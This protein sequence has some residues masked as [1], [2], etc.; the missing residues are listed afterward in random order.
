MRASSS[1]CFFQ[2]A[3]TPSIHRICL[4]S[5]VLFAIVVA[6][7]ARA[8]DLKV[9]KV[10]L[11]S[12]TVTS[13]PPGINCGGDCNEMYPSTA[14]VTLTATPDA[15]SV[16]VR[17]EGDGAGTANPTVVTMGS[18]RSVRAIFRL[19]TPF[20]PITDFSP[21]GLRTYLSANPDV[22]TA[23]RFMSA[24]PNDF[25]QNWILMTRSESLQTGTALFPRILLPSA[26][27]R[28]VFTLGLAEHSSYP[29]AHPDAIEYMQWDAAQK[30]FRFHEVILRNVPAMGD[31]ISPT[32]RRF[33][34]RPRGVSIDDAKCS[35]CHS[36]RNVVNLN[37]TVIPP[38]PG[39]FPATDGV[40]PGTVKAK[41]KPNW[42]AYDS[43][44]GMMPFNRDRIYQGS[45]EAAAFRRLLNL[46]TWSNNPP[47][48]SI[49]EQL[50]LQPPD[51]FLPGGALDMA[52]SIPRDHVI[53][54]TEGGPQ[55]GHINFVFDTAPPISTEPA[56]SGPASLQT[57]YAFEGVA[58]PP[59]T[60]TT[61]SIVWGGTFITLHHSNIPTSDEGRG[62]R[63][64]DALGG[65]ASIDADGDGVL[66]GNLNA[67][68]ITDELISHRFA[69]GSRPIDIRPIALAITKEM[70]RV[71]AAG[72]TVV[73]TPALTIDLGFFEA[74]HG[75]LRI[76]D[77]VAD[78]RA[79]A[80]LLP[81]R[82][83]DIQKRN[84]DRTDDVYLSPADQAAPDGANGLIQQYGAD[85]SAGAVATLDK[86]RQEVFRR[87]VDLGRGDVTV[88]NR[89]YVDREEYGTND[90]PT[91]P[92][93]TDPNTE[94][95]ALFR[96]FLEPL[97]VSVDKWSMGV[98]GR[99]RTYTF[100]DVFRAYTNH[101]KIA[102]RSSLLNPADMVP[103]L[104]NPDNDTQLI[105][106]VNSTLGFLPLAT[107]VPRYTDVQR[108]FNKSC[109]EC[110]GGLGYPP[111]HNYGTFVDLSENEDPPSGLP[112]MPS[113]RLLRSYDTA[114]AL[115]VGGLTFG[116][117][118]R[119]TR[120]GTLEN[121]R[122]GL[123]D[124]MPCG[125]PRL[126]QADIDTIRRWIQG[127]PARPSTTGDP[128]ITTVDGVNYDFQAAGEFVLLR[129]EYLEIQARQTAVQTAGPLG[130][131]PHTGLTSCVSVN[132][133][134]AVR[135]GSHRITYQPNLGGQSEGRGLQLRVDGK[136]VELGS[137]GIP[138]ASG[139]R[140]VRTAAP[141][142]IQLEAAGGL[143][144]VVTPGWWPQHQL[145]FLNIDTRN[146]RAITGLMGTI[147]PGNWLPALPEGT[148][149]GP[150]P[151]DL[152][153]RFQDLYVKFGNAWRVTDATSL[154]DYAP[155][156]STRTFQLTSFPNEDP[157]VP[158]TVPPL[159]GSINGPPAA[160][161][162]F[163]EAEACC[164]GILNS[165]RKANCIK[166]VMVTGEC[167]FG[168]TYILA[169]QI[170]RNRYPTFPTLV[171]PPD[172]ATNLVGPIS[173]TWNH[174]N[175]ADGDPITYRHYVWPV[176]DRPNNNNA[177]PVVLQAGLS[178][179]GDA[180]ARL[181]AW[182]ACLL[183][184]ALVLLGLKK[185]PGLPIVLVLAILAVVALVY[186]RGRRANVPVTNAQ[187]VT[188]TVVDLQPHQAYFWKVIAEDGQ[189]GTV[190]SET[191][192]LEMK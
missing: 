4:A 81:R 125:G 6:S 48:R 161:L 74:R 10:G 184:A 159:P 71:N 89:I 82:K 58:G 85:T 131:N 27:C 111:Y 107:E 99:S 17:W 72:N 50:E 87:P 79:R 94:K 14:T 133:A 7:P 106:A 1:S 97:G 16:F 116:I 182:L 139:A 181:A 140:V 164:A 66:D 98:R 162:T 167:G 24:L 29:G 56:P 115:T 30:N 138:L 57:T 127:P 122:L 11:G 190:E 102:L 108:I 174:A 186:Y 149:L 12:G 191:R 142:G 19:A 118:E 146:V 187:M 77:L 60:A 64:F 78:T 156:T 2:L 128:H 26:D 173:F 22:N 43:W 165:T 185:R 157:A 95:I 160:P 137:G 84:L 121:C 49:V 144:I 75:G 70:I 117:Y 80:E 163:A 170:D 152:S 134:V 105:N 31:L 83:A 68:R 171:F 153:Q 45:V 178:G 61:P 44:G 192:R 15:G 32:E 158:C 55:D 28:F 33:P 9:L 175:D 62:V 63:F 136:L 90:D 34:L 65:L 67:Q 151:S 141:G 53:T 76:N 88:M 113:P 119:I 154:F 110:H 8:A 126:S 35:K 132:T 103:G 104:T 169:D 25:K 166:D 101:F 112:S 124:V 3:K 155:G 145:W 5:M 47:V 92:D 40:P 135:I 21:E 189:G 143:V 36:T 93:Y 147:A 109:I 120:A 86:V 23:A 73:S 188:A 176:N 51:R 18:H 42:D 52:R 114:A 91:S 41:N 130:P 129:D 54:R 123:I 100:A 96:F 179:G 69:T 13:A 172:R 20:P 39:S 183:L 180:C 177:K 168:K 59:I 150:K 46:W 38:V 37:R 148:E